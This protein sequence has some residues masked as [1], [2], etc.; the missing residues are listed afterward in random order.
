VREKQLD[1]VTIADVAKLAGVSTS[2]AGRVLGGYGYASEEIR[3]RVR[4]SA[5]RLAYRP[6]LVARGLITGKTKT[7]GIIAGDIQSP[8][9]ASILRGV[10]DV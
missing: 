2:T 3:S 8:F 4:Q 10:A 7:I 1:K 9:Y 6:N 5:E